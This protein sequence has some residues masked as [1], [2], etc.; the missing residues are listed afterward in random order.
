M[1]FLGAVP[2]SS[3]WDACFMHYSS[4][5][6][7]ILPLVDNRYGSR[8]YAFSD[9]SATRFLFPRFKSTKPARD[10]ESQHIKEDEDHDQVRSYSCAAFLG[11]AA[12][13][14]I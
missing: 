2:D 10:L 3:S 13:E 14:F 1:G 9:I 11:I 7:A 6:S 12:T 4:G 8:P 5:S